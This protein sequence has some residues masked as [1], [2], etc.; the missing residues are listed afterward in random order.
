VEATDE[1]PS[2]FY[3]GTL[4]TEEGVIHCGDGATSGGN[5]GNTGS[6]G[7]TGGDDD[8]DFNGNLGE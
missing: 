6:G 2:P 1:I 7:N 3:V 8:D 4:D 5:T